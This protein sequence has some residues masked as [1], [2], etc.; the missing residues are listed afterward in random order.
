MGDNKLLKPPK[1]QQQKTNCKY[2]DVLSVCKIRHLKK[3]TKVKKT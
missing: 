2:S 3:N 1:T